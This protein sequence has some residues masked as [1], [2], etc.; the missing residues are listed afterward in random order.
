M[1]S[2]CCF[3]KLCIC[4]SVTLRS[5]KYFSSKSEKSSK[6]IFC[7]HQNRQFYH[8]KSMEKMLHFDYAYIFWIHCFVVQRILKITFYV[9]FNERLLSDH[10]PAPDRRRWSDELNYSDDLQ[11]R[12]ADYLLR[13]PKPEQHSVIP[14]RSSPDSRFR[15]GVL[16]K[17]NGVFKWRVGPC[18][19]IGEPLRRGPPILK[20]RPLPPLKGRPFSLLLTSLESSTKFL[21]QW[22]KMKKKRDNDIF[23]H[24]QNVP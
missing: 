1:I 24:Y 21:A 2:G 17:V 19:K 9:V 11:S 20:Q 3:N 13:T 12:D 23:F 15:E 5:E 16:R 6:H 10:V 22:E 4:S 7:R 8:Q 18:F 14:A